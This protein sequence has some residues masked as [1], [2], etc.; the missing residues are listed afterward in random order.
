[1]PYAIGPFP[2]PHL[3]LQFGGSLPGTEGWS[4]GIRFGQS[5]AGAGEFGAVPGML[6]P[7]KN[8][9]STWFTSAGAKISSL[10][11]LQFVK[12][13]AIDVNGHYVYPD[14]NEVLLSVAGGAAGTVPPNQVCLAASWTTGVARG[15]AH[16]GR[17]YVPLPVV[18]LDVDGRI[19]DT[20]ATTMKAVLTTLLTTL[21][22]L[23][24]T[25][26]PAIFSRKAGAPAYRLI[27][28][29]QVGRVLDTQRRRRRSLLESYV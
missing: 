20:N 12:L 3:Y 10:A 21:Q 17:M 13:N 2:D 14:T 23:H 8:A 26:K 18:P 27:T 4:C 7:A 22:G 11:S 29:V 28:G 16:R 1:M 6:V 19:S 9:L 25:W 15:P 5:P 24:A